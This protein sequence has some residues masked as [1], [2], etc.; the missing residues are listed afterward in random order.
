VLEVERDRL[1]VPV[2]PGE[3]RAQPV[4][5]VVVPAGEVAADAVLHLDDARAQITEMARANR[6]R[7]RLL[8]GDDGDT[9]Q[10][11]HGRTFLHGRE[12][13]AWE[14]KQ[15]FVQTNGC[16]AFDFLTCRTRPAVDGGSPDVKI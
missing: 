15:R 8:H 16:A 1:L 14:S 3:V 9:C 4:D 13:R 11:V 10:R 2:C 6:R 12:S 5:H 7:D